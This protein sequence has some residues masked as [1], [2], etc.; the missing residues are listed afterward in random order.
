MSRR[1]RLDG[2][3]DGVM[4]GLKDSVHQDSPVVD[5]IDVGGCKVNPSEIND[6]VGLVRVAAA[7]GGVEG[8]EEGKGIGLGP[9]NKVVGSRRGGPGWSVGEGPGWVVEIKIS[10]DQGGGVQWEV[11]VEQGLDSAR[12]ASGASIV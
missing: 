7:C 3:A 1:Q 4:V 5:K 2:P 9:L 6:R 8:V 10:Q 11:R 12:E